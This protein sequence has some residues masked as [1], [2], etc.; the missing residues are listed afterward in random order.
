MTE[1]ACHWTATKT[2]LLHNDTAVSTPS[3]IVFVQQFLVFPIGL[4]L[5]ETPMV[6][7]YLI[8]F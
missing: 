4:D 8:R 6:E 7:L 3:A 2:K 5:D 1:F